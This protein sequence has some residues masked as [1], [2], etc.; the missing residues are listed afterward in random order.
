[1]NGS[2]TTVKYFSEVCY[3]NFRAVRLLIFFA[4]KTENLAFIITGVCRSASCYV[5]VL[6]NPPIPGHHVGLLDRLFYLNTKIP[7]LALSGFVTLGIRYVESTLYLKSGLLSTLYSSPII[8]LCFRV[9]A[10][11][12]PW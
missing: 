1:M 8:T 6:M 3:S 7:L 2:D 10:S 9:I 4:F 5:L 12:R 11:L